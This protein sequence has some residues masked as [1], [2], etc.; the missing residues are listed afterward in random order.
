MDSDKQK[1]PPHHFVVDS[2]L[3]NIIGQELITN[4]FVAIYE[5]VKNSLDAHATKVDLVIENDLI[6]IA[7][8][9]KGMLVDNNV[10]EIKSK[11][12]RVA[13]SAKKQGVE[14]QN[15][16]NDFREKIATRKRALGGNKG[17]GRFSCDRLGKD[18]TLYT[19]TSLQVTY[20]K[21][22]ISWNDFEDNDLVKFENIG[23]KRTTVNSLPDHID[24]LLN[25]A[26]TIL[27]ISDLRSDWNYKKLQSLKK[28]LAQLINP[29]EEN[30]DIQIEIHAKEYIKQDSETE[31]EFSKVNGLV[32]NNIYETIGLSTTKIEV[33]LRNGSI[34]TKLI[35]RGEL[36]YEIEENSDLDHINDIPINIDLSFLNR[37]AKTRF[38]RF[39]GITAL[40][41]GHVFLFK[42]G[43]RVMPYGVRGNDIL[44]FDDRKS[45]GQ[46][47]YLG[48]RDLLGQINILDNSPD[49]I[50]P[51]SRDGGLIRNAAYLDLEQLF[52]KNALVRL[53]AY[54]VGITFKD[55]TDK[56][57]EDNS[58]IYKEKARIGI[59]EIINKLV[60]N[61]QIE[62]INYHKELVDI[63]D[64]KSSDF[65][66]TVKNLKQ[67]ATASKNTYL[68]N[69][70]RSAELKYSALEKAKKE[71][72]AASAKARQTAAEEYA[73][74]KEALEAQ[75][76]AEAKLETEIKRSLFLK[77]LTEVDVEDVIGLSHQVIFD[78]T[79]IKN[80]V[81]DALERITLDS[82]YFNE[83]V[84]L[85]IL[86]SIS[87]SNQKVLLASQFAT[88][89]NFRH[90]SDGITEDMVAFLK[91]YILVSV[92]PN[93]FNID[94]TLDTDEGIEFTRTFKPLE[95]SIIIDNFVSNAQKARAPHINFKITIK[96]GA[97]NII[98]SDDGDGLG[99]EIDISRIFDLAY[100]GTQGS[101]IGLYH[102]KSVLKQLNGSVKLLKTSNNEAKFLVEIK[103]EN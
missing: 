97:L 21:L 57:K 95:L 84:A 77:S 14:D 44:G 79:N 73:K 28:E 60:R 1:A 32:S 8:N 41:F 103:D 94:V 50:E 5:L 85:Q 51:S 78:A 23:V 36:I 12:L 72:D 92:N 39:M 74:A 102:I 83:S 68:L 63:I 64:E 7:D 20:N 24:T 31:A 16:N 10:D 35:D 11:W 49:L 40:D 91:D 90:Q 54:V 66:S 46:M 6:I 62:I 75:K 59:I 19:K 86:Q 65:T 98:V 87:L 29:F 43:Y 17:V 38:T 25:S 58:G 13:Y 30:K 47:R 52:K 42:N 26:N 82:E 18:L 3:K 15:L 70:I 96:D 48:S 89:A 81:N 4:D 34:H 67:I 93:A 9:G 88:R 55:K 76:L 45:Q 80:T 101:G 37:A 33:K 61:D 69:Q 56:D 71:A 2:G 99:S 27:E 53:E 100:S 22:D